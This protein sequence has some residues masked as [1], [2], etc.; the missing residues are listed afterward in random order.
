[1]KKITATLALSLLP[2]YA[3]AGVFDALITVTNPDTQAQ[4]SKSFSFDT[5]NNFFDQLKEK[6]FKPSFPGYNS[7]W[8]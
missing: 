4:S 7:T 3:F 5:A 8:G 1:M 2:Y 6:G